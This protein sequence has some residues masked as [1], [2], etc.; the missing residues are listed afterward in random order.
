M[1]DLEMR[2]SDSAKPKGIAN[3]NATST[4]E[5]DIRKPLKTT[6]RLWTKMTGFK[7]RRRN[8]LEF[9]ASTHGCSLRSAKKLSKALT[10]LIST[11]GILETFLAEPSASV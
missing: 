9:H 4:I 6:G 5:S 11:E 7:N 10:P 8:I 3:G 2:M 1:R